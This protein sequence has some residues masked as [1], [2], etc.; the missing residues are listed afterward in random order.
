MRVVIG[1]SIANP[2][3]TTYLGVKEFWASCLLILKG[4][5][6][7]RVDR[8]VP[9]YSLYEDFP[10]AYATTDLPQALFHRLCIRVMSHNFE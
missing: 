5:S 1:H 9:T 6:T 3:E 2:S 7:P 8:D 4:E 10:N